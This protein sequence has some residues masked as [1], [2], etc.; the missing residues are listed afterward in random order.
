MKSENCKFYFIYGMVV[1]DDCVLY[2]H[3]VYI[4]NCVC[5]VYAICT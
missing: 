5:V 1:S 3:R 4:V 2:G